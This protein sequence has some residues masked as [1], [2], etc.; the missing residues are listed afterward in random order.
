MSYLIVGGLKGLCG[1]SLDIYRVQLGAKYLVVLSNSGYGD[2]GSHRALKNI[3]DQGCRVDLVQGDV[4][5]LK[6]VQRAFES[7][8]VR[9]GTVSHRAMVLRVENTVTQFRLYISY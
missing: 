4:S 5:N 7:A 9:V 3:Y 1:G 6:D 8:T 2:G